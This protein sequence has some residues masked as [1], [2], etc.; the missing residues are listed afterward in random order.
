MLV[1]STM[2]EAE[3][4]MNGREAAQTGQA[5]ASAPSNAQVAPAA[6]RNRTP[7]WVWLWFLPVLLLIFLYLTRNV[8]GP[9]VI[10]GMLAYIFSMV[11]DRIQ[12][13]LGWPR[14][15]IVGLLYALVLGLIAV[16]L[17]FGS[18]SLYQQTQSFITG[19]PNIVERG[20]EQFL[21]NNSFTF[22][23]TTV[24]AHAIAQRVNEV[25]SSYSGG[26]GDA[27]HV[28]VLVGE[29]LLD[30]LLVLIVTFYL[31]LSGKNLG[32]Y[33]LKFVPSGARARTGYLA[34]RIH[35]TLGAY[36]RGQL[37]LILLMAF[38]SFLLLAF[39]FHLPYAFPL[40]VLTGFLEIIPLLGP[41]IATTI[42]AAVALASQGPTTALWVIVAYFVLRQLEDQLVM[43]MVVGKI[44]E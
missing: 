36:L 16:G 23:G 2:A 14:I 13:K 28:L 22:G 8:L 31:L 30:V 19:G 11:I 27:V 9:F 12:E 38:V 43:P 41:A 17:Y 26:G 37:S 35:V 6:S 42:A 39:V 44:V 7:P 32:S 29:R 5:A 3:L 20:V 25:V 34:G 15:A 4:D 10:A 18:E 21:G 24:D 1:G 40:A 33:L